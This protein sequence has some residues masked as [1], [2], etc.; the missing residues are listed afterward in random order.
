MTK[1][2]D[3]HKLNLLLTTLFIL[4]GGLTAYLLYRLPQKLMVPY[5]Y[6]EV[7]AVTYVAAAATFLLGILI[8]TQAMSYRKELIV[9]RDR[10][11]EITQAE[12][13]ADRKDRITID[14]LK[15]SFQQASSKK[16]ILHS[17]LEALCRQLDAGQGA[18]YLIQPDGNT[19][20]VVLTTGFALTVN[21]TSATRY[22]FGEGLIGQAAASGQL[23]YLDEVP[24]GYIKI[25]SG[26]GSASPRYLIIVPVKHNEKVQGVLEIASFAP[27][28]EEQRRFIEQGA[29]LIAEKL[30]TY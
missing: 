16:E 7:L 19:K 28:S 6:E 8:I 26:L 24:E 20:V 22:T 25:I 2:K 3:P 11:D 17:G 21:E 10:T 23:L 1:A 5:G 29:Q 15:A 27:F 18:A 30:S 9:F 4:G 14:T 13:E 12:H